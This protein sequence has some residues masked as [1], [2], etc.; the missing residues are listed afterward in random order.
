MEDGHI[1]GNSFAVLV[2]RPAQRLPKSWERVGAQHKRQIMNAYRCVIHIL[3]I[4]LILLTSCRKEETG[5]A[6]SSSEAMLSKAARP[7]PS[8]LVKGDP[9]CFDVMRDCIWEAPTCNS[10]GEMPIDNSCTPGYLCAGG[11]AFLKG[12]GANYGPWH[13]IQPRT[14]PN[15][16]KCLRVRFTG[17]ASSITAGYYN[18]TTG[19]W[20]VL[21][22]PNF[23]AQQVTPPAGC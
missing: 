11:V 10:N 18:A 19:Q 7:T 14:R 22:G 6:P 17:A 15:G 21:S 2:L 12:S 3:P 8:Y 5:D 9:A 13:V 1:E 4:T 20:T 23:Q 16:F